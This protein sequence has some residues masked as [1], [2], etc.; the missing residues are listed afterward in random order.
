M[1]L[2]KED[3]QGRTR[4]QADLPWLGEHVL[5]LRPS[6]CVLLR[7]ICVRFGELL[8]LWCEDAQLF[9]WN[10]TTTVDALDVARSDVVRFP[11]TGRIMDIKKHVF[12]ADRVADLP[13]FHVPEVRALFLGEDLVE[14]IWS[15]GLTGTTF[16]EVWHAE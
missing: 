5:V 2:L 14:L 13:A 9:A 1:E 7:D 3:E 8:P 15:A 10:A 12:Y 4:R 6:A 11:S 16:R